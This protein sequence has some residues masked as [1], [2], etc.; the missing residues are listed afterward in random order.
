M[1]NK[2]AIISSVYFPRSS[3]GKLQS[4]KITLESIVHNAG[5]EF[6]LYICIDGLE[7]E[8][9]N[10]Y[11]NMVNK[12]SGPYLK[13]KIIT[14]NEKNEGISVS[15]NKM[16][17]LIDDTYTHICTLD[18]DSLHPP[19]WL[20]K[21]CLVLNGF[22]KAGVC[23]VLVEDHLRNG[24]EKGIGS[25]IEEI[26][27]GKNYIQFTFPD[28]I[29]GACLVFRANELKSIKYEE[30]LKICHV[31]AYILSRFMLLGYSVCAILDRGFHFSRDE[32]ESPEWRKAKL[33]NWDRELVILRNSLKEYT[34]K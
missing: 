11:I 30:T 9:E 16:L 8:I 32:I 21:C 6:D 2:V 31:D 25:C 14:R 24:I 20:Y 22:N 18:L 23:G 17:S 10:D 13:S 28:A 4:A 15:F 29:G 19:N 26:D 34:K 5:V 3:I 7:S 12:V 1:K 33:D 27:R